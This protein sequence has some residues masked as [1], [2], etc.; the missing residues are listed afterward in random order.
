MRKPRSISEKAALV[1]LAFFLLLAPAGAG[2]AQ[3]GFQADPDGPT[4]DEEDRPATDGGG[5]VDLTIDDGTAETFIGDLGQFLWLNRF[6]PAP[7]AFPLELQEIQVVYGA[8]AVPIGGDVDLVVYEDTDGDG[9]PGTGA[10][11]LATY[12]ETV[13]SND[14]ATFNVYTLTPTVTLN[15]PGD[16]L[17]GVVNRYG[18]EGNN[19]FPAALD[20][21][22][23][24]VRSWAASYLAG[25]APE[26]PFLPADE[27][28]GTIDSFG[29]PG[30]WV[31]RASGETIVP[32]TIEVPTLS[33]AG[34]ALLL[35]L[36]AGGAVW[37][38]RR[39]QAG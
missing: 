15:G 31:V 32:P 3:S 17:V 19:D 6:T 18:F 26:P 16:V 20:Q 27:Q 25:D 4:V 38:L 14:G 7:G 5:P 9:D 28:W 13:I 33:W 1:V 37:I 22:S 8:T 11:H 39:Q 35:T 30:N 34:L 36:L 24:Q 2:L 21:S 12:D 10:V 29:F 23:A